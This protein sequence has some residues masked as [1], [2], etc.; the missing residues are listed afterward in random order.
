VPR[1]NR[2]KRAQPPDDDDG[3]RPPDVVVGAPEGWQARTSSKPG[4]YACPGCNKQFRDVGQHVVTWRSDGTGDRRH[5]HR[6]CYQR[7]AR[8]R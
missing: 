8:G 5:W 4:P 1:R 2:P 3:F 6:T 7:W